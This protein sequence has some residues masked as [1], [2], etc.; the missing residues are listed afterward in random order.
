M[1]LLDE[2][3]R[4]MKKVNIYIWCSKAQVGKIINYFENINC[5]IDILT[6]HKTNPTPTINNTYA[7][8]TEYCIFAREKGVKIYG[9]YE[10]KRKYYVTGANVEDKKKFNHPTIKPLEIIKNLIINSSNENDVVFDPFM[11]SGT[12]AVAAKQLNRQFIG[13][14][15]DKEYHRIA[16]ERLEGITQEKEK[17]VGKNQLSIFDIM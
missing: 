1:K 11:G 14:E 16:C 17:G 10:T 13:F 4:I 7:N 8:D 12:T 3:V 5:N 9:C 2:F 6:W 15:I